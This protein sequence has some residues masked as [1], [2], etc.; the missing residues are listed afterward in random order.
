MTMMGVYLYES[1]GR[2]D[3]FRSAKPL[4]GLTRVPRVRILHSK[5]A[6]EDK[7]VSMILG[8]TRTVSVLSCLLIKYGARRVTALLSPLSRSK[9]FYCIVNCDDLGL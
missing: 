4:Y 1:N 7:G 6:I 5:P 9:Y 2:A 8:I 3:N